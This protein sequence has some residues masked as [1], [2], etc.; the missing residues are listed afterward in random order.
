MTVLLNKPIEIGFTILE[1]SKVIMHK[2]WMKLKEIFDDRITLT[3]TDTNSVKVRIESKDPYLELKNHY[4]DKL[5]TSNIKKDTELPYTPGLNRKIS[6]LLKNENG[7]DIMI[8][9]R[10][11][12]S[13]NYIEMTH[14]NN[15]VTNKGIKKRLRNKQTPKDFE[16]FIFNNNVH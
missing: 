3:Y 9:F 15:K 14:S 6:S 1:I 16:E 13:K 5:D 4:N 2:R 7:D 11:C 10:D 8:G 12:S